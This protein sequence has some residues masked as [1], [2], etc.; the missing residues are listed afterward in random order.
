MRVMAGEI[1][2]VFCSPGK[3]PVPVSS[4]G[5]KPVYRFVLFNFLFFKTNKWVKFESLLG[6]GS[7]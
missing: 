4:G 3:F 6:G 2:D 1:L 7:R 5:I